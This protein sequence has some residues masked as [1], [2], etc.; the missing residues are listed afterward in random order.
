M[1]KFS[2]ISALLNS[3]INQ[4]KRFA[5]VN[6]PYKQLQIS[7]LV[8]KKIYERSVKGNLKSCMEEQ[9]WRFRLCM[10]SPELPDLAGF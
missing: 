1:S 4:H 2:E 7:P 9:N 5:T 3:P 6:P 10:I 8:I